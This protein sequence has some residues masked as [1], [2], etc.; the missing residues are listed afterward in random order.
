MP[1]IVLGSVLISGKE[2]NN[3]EKG[4][5]EGGRECVCVCVCVFVS[6]LLFYFHLS[7]VDR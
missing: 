4:D 2:K 1:G 6:V 7:W 5:R 3:V